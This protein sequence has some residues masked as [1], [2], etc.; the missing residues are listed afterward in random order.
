MT[1]NVNTH[2]VPSK[3]LRRDV[4][5]FVNGCLQQCRV[6]ARVSGHF[7]SAFGVVGFLRVKDEQK[8]VHI[9]E[10]SASACNEAQIQEEKAQRQQQGNNQETQEKQT[11]DR[12]ETKSRHS[13]S[14]GSIDEP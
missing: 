8:S 12:R 7:V 11:G 9:A 4:H 5:T 2:S 14:T 13:V 3:A 10:A 1:T 6:A